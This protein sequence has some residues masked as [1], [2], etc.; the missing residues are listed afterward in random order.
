MPSP[1]VVALSSDT[2]LCSS[3]PHSPRLHFTLPGLTVRVLS[4]F[5]DPEVLEDGNFS[6]CQGRVTLP[7]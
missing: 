6:G 2:S 1:S 5:L 7:S 3:Q 4:S